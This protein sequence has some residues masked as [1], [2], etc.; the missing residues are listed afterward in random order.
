MTTAA[1]AAEYKSNIGHDFTLSDAYETE[2]LEEDK[3]ARDAR[4]DEDAAPLA[5]ASG[6][7]G[8]RVGPFLI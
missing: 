7:K 5:C 6:A 4:R 2:Y 1:A 3:E 8:E